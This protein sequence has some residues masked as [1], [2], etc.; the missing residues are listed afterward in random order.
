MKT[1]AQFIPIDRQQWERVRSELCHDW[2]KNSMLVAISKMCNLL[3]GSVLDEHG[4]TDL[5]A[6]LDGSGSHLVIVEQ[7]IANAPAALSPQAALMKCGVEAPLSDGFASPFRLVVAMWEENSGIKEATERS[8]VT[9]AVVRE[10]IRESRNALT[11]LTEPSKVQ[12]RMLLRSMQRID[13][14][15][16]DLASALTDLGKVKSYS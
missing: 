14:A 16:R 11:P 6:L 10:V 4:V 9:L 15:L 2:I 13:S 8:K 5:M 12:T 7:L 3:N 1:R